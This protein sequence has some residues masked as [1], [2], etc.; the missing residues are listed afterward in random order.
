[1]KLRNVLI[2]SAVSLG[3]A[4]GSTALALGGFAPWQGLPELPE[5][6]HAQ[7]IELVEAHPF[8]LDVPEVHYY[9]AEQPSYD[10]GLLLVL[11]TERDMLV[12]RQTLEPVLYVG[13][14][15]AERVNFGGDSGHAIVIVP[16]M[17]LEALAESPIY[18]G[19]PEL[20]ERVTAGSAAL[21]LDA[22]R[23]AGI[24]APAAVQD[25]ARPATQFEDGYELR[26]FASTLIEV[27]SPS[28][29]DLVE[30]LRA[31]RVGR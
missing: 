10:S 29:R 22:A 8:G 28:E 27:Y 15:T 21:E 4:G 16:G 3:L 5:N 26:E 1:M 14:E 13:S 25:A 9:R 20:P 12:P 7:G 2:L 17:T 6:L 24:A 18:F 23:A 19:T 11:R 30:G 31:P